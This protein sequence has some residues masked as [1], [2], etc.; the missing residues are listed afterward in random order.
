[1][2]HRGVTLTLTLSL[3]GEGTK[4]GILIF[5]FNGEGIRLGILTLSHEVKRQSANRVFLSSSRGRGQVRGW[6]IEVSPSP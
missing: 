6:S 2:V 3:K 4:P 1:V 5:Y